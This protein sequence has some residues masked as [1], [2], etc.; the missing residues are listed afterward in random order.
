[1]R[2]FL[3][4]M[5]QPAIRHHHRRLLHLLV[6]PLGGD[7]IQP[8]KDA[9]AGQTAASGEGEGGGTGSAEARAKESSKVFLFITA[10]SSPLY[11]LHK[12]RKSV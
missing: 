11:K 5:C 12:H 9:G 7:S 1:M 3:P 10:A 2:L 4:S 8:S 6:G